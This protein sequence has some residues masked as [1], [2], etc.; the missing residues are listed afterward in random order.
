MIL[1]KFDDFINESVNDK[2]ALLDILREYGVFNPAEFMNYL[3]ELGYTIIEFDP[4][5]RGIK[6]SFD[7]FDKI[8]EY[9]E[10]FD[11]VFD[12]EE[13]KLHNFLI[14]KG[15]ENPDSFFNELYDNFGIAIVKDSEWEPMDESINEELDI[16]DMKNKLR[17]KFNPSMFE[18]ISKISRIMMNVS[19]HGLRVGLDLPGDEQYLH[20]LGYI[21]ES[22]KALKSILRL[23]NWMEKKKNN[24]DLSSE[25]AK[26]FN[27]FIQYVIKEM[28]YRYPW[29][30][31][32]HLTDFE[33]DDLNTL[34]QTYN[35]LVDRYTGKKLPKKLYN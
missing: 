4:V 2:Y 24:R 19:T 20:V 21:Y 31:E 16:D 25:E 1:K 35:E 33:Q 17:K 18:R 28:N 27:D 5:G 23:E 26:Q 30:F 13:D 3:N 14:V 6:E 15:V 32:G 9:D 11:E 8:F 10:Y 22:I 34:V 29:K 12:D 7:T